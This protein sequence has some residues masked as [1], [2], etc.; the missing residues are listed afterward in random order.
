MS[1]LW[2][3]LHNRTTIENLKFQ[4]WK[5]DKKTGK[6]TFIPMF[7]ESG[8][9]IFDQGIR[10]N[11]IEVMGDRKLFWLCKLKREIIFFFMY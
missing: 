10:A 8:E 9:N 11:W 6:N 2:L 5:K 7:T 1:H 4:N 3:V